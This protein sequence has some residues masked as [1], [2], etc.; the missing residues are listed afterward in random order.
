MD[1]YSPAVSNGSRVHASQ[2]FN[3]NT[4]SGAS[5]K[6]FCA[7]AVVQALPILFGLSWDARDG[8]CQ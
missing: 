6:A 7:T 4:S 1:E 2:A 3:L 5:L 8:H